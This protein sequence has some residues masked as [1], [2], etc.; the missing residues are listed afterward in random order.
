VSHKN[1]RG[2]QDSYSPDVP[3]WA[4]DNLVLKLLDDQGFSLEVVYDRK[5]LNG[6]N[7]KPLIVITAKRRAPRYWK[8]RT[9]RF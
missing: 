5:F 2:V 8:Q 1:Q 4:R 6:L 9:L 3:A 7:S